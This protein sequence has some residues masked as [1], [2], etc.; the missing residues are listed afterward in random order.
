MITVPAGD[1]QAI[2][3]CVSCPTGIWPA[4]GPPWTAAHEMGHGMGLRDPYDE[5]GP[6]PGC[7]DNIMGARDRS[8]SEDDILEIVRKNR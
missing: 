5:N 1:G 8:P 6:F 4:D 2:M 7:E 3:R